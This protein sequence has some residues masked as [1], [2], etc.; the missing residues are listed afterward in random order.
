MEQIIEQPRTARS[1][2]VITV[3]S[4]LTGEPVGEVPRA[5]AADVVTA[6]ER[7]RAAQPEWAALPFDKRAEVILRFH[8]LIIQ[9]REELFD[10]LQS[11]TGKS[12]RDA[13]VEL[14]AVAAEARYYA[15][16]G[17]EFLAAHRTKSAIPL[18][19]VTRVRYEPVGV[20][21]VISPWNFPFILTA[22]DTI[23]AL[24]AGNAVVLKPASLTPLTALW[25]A[26]KMAEAGL[27]ES[28]L[29]I[30]AGPGR[31]LGSAIIDNVDYIMFTGSTAVGKSVA[32][33]AAR[34]LIPASMELGGKNA[35]VVLSDANIPHAAQV[36]LE[37]AFNNAGQVCIDIERLY[38]MQDIYDVFVSEL[39]RQ[40]AELRLGSDHT[41][42]NDIGSLISAEQFELVEE[43]VQD[44]VSKGARVLAGGRPRPDV[45]PLFYEPTILEGVRAGMTVYREE[46]FGP[47]LSVYPVATPEEAVEQVNDSR[48]GLYHVVGTGN[49]QRGE[50]IASQ[51][52]A[53][54]VTIN[55]SYMGWAAMAAPMGGFKE[56][57]I[58]RRHGPEG[59]R[60]YTNSQTILYNRTNWQIGSGETAL[61]FNERLAD[62]L[63]AL[64][65]LWRYI[66]FLR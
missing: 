24:L 54:T 16:H 30:V 9:Q 12:R 41:Y 18:R 47:V 39:V 3:T 28:L 26:E 4:P 56:S 52:Q 44:A 13:F 11:E 49:R 63:A 51:L 65:K 35:M 38:V 60:K 21:G 66:P 17:E 53:G 36:A 22:G 2:P 59:I 6:V 1:Q 58:G 64:L 7:A 42:N 31:E 15:Y 25:M 14:F 45:G 19:D 61:A 32:E 57:G 10:V 48:Y 55:D 29:Q 50:E 40:A 46:T 20:V 37:A 5:S 43:H 8:N 27:P 23:P 34:R 33:Q 62:L